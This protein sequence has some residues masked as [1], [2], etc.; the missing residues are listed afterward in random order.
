MKKLLAVSLEL[1]VHIFFVG[2][3]LY[4]LLS[5]WGVKS[6]HYQQILKGEIPQKQ[7]VMEEAPKDQDSQSAQEETTQPIDIIER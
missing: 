5:S 1:F 2:A 4:A 6:E 7:F 3:F